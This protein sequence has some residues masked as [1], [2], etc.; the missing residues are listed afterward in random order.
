MGGQSEIALEYYQF[1]LDIQ[2]QMHKDVPHPDIVESLIK[3][4]TLLR[5]L[6]EWETAHSFFTQA[7]KLGIDL[8]LADQYHLDVEIFFCTI[9]I[10]N[11]DMYSDGKTE[12]TDG[13]VRSLTNTML[14]SVIKQLITFQEILPVISCY[15]VLEKIVAPD[16]IN[17]KHEL[18]CYYHIIALSKK[19]KNRYQEFIKYL[20][21]T[22]E[23]FEKALTLGDITASLYTEYAMFLIKHHNTNNL[24]EYTKIQLLLQKVIEVRDD[25]VNLNYGKLEKLTTIDP[26]QELLEEQD[27][28]SIKPYSLAC[29]LLAIVH[30]MHGRRKEAEGMLNK[31]QLVTIS[32]EERNEKKYLN[33][34]LS[35]LLKNYQTNFLNQLQL[36]SILGE[37]I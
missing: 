19:S 8:Q 24:N 12:E 21:K 30:I 26:I 25:K 10:M 23:I 11:K 36:F 37:N 29:Y 4:G 16:D 17:V 15:E 32:F 20:E 2:K 7:K 27:Q 6:E 33:I 35:M 9:V 14:R 31:L 1:V 34:Y 22:K 18:A 28:I 13:V 3:I 5:E